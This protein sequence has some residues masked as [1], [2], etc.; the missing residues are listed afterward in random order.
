[1]EEAMGQRKQHKKDT[2]SLTVS[3]IRRV[4]NRQRGGSHREEM[5]IKMR[6]EAEG[7]QSQD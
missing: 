5:P 3:R 6:Q 4:I 7:V 1:M 2:T